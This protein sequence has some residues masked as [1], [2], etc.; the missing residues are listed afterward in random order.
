MPHV[1]T[2]EKRASSARKNAITHDQ[3]EDFFYVIGNIFPF[4]S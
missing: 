4:H 3:V 2:H 1:S